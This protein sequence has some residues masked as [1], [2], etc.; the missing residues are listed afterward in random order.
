MNDE[1]ILIEKLKL[2]EALHSGTN[3][4][5][6]RQAAESARERILGRLRT[7]Q[8]QEKPIEYRFALPDPWARKLF[9]ALARRYDLKPFRYPGQRHASVMLKVPKSFV[10][11]TLWPEFQE[12]NLTLKNY[13]SNITEKVIRESIHRDASEA[14]VRQES[15]SLGSGIEMGSS[16]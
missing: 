16:E 8:G 6:E 15:L 13:L 14:E 5:G 7:I 2:I 11:E 4:A 9:I 3:H 10:D 12:L 1:Q